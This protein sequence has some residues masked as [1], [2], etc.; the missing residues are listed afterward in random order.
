MH[1]TEISGAAPG[2]MTSDQSC[3]TVT[4]SFQHVEAFA[5]RITD[6]ESG[7]LKR[8]LIHKSIFNL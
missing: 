4:W 6:S 3:L 8:F 5:S 1:S 2:G 7:I